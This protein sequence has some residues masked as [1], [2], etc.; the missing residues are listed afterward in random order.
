MIARLLMLLALGTLGLSGAAMAQDAPMVGMAGCATEAARCP[1]G[2][3]A[4]PMSHRT[5]CCVLAP[6]AFAV[7]DRAQLEPVTM[8]AAIPVVLIPRDVRPLD[9]PPRPL[10]QAEHSI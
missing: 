6:V 10:G 2:K 7:P 5:I 1:E 3:G 9:P 4:M 8:R